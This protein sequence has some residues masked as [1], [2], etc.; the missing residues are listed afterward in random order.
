MREYRE[1]F[2]KFLVLSVLTFAAYLAGGWALWRF[3]DRGD[4]PPVAEGDRN[5]EGTFVRTQIG[6]E[7]I[8]AHSWSGWYESPVHGVSVE[9][10]PPQAE[11]IAKIEARWPN[12]AVQQIDGHFGKRDFAEDLV[13]ARIWNGASSR[14]LA[15]FFTWRPLEY[16]EGDVEKG[17]RLEKVTTLSLQPGEWSDWVVQPDGTDELVVQ[18][19][20]YAEAFVKCGL[21]LDDGTMQVV[22]AA[23]RWTGQKVHGVRLRND[24]ANPV[25]ATILAWRPIATSSAGNASQTSAPSQ[26]YRYDQPEQA[27]AR[28]PAPR[29]ARSESAATSQPTRR[30]I[31][32]GYI[33]KG[34]RLET[35][36]QLALSPGEWS[37]WIVRPT[38]SS[39]VIV[40]VDNENAW[41]C[42]LRFL[43]DTEEEFQVADRAAWRRA[44]KAVRVRND[45]RASAIATVFAWRRLGVNVHAT[46]LQGV[47]PPSGWDTTRISRVFVPPLGWTN[48][49]ER[50]EGGW[51]M[52]VG[53]SDTSLNQG[54]TA[55]VRLPDGTVQQINNTDWRKISR[56]VV[57]ARVHNPASDRSVVVMF[58]TWRNQ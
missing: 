17:E 19:D 37:D 48:W 54:F 31:G 47:D 21:R 57:A 51:G 39:S 1:G 30:K 33:D 52:A 34:E 58:Y 24:G 13:A 7:E 5:T 18:M 46:A 43:D 25:S 28:S 35:V 53:Y 41:R 26:P 3:I 23:E 44:A 9:M 38:D 14:V 36:A 27:P 16:H 10:I 45:G 8:P 50:P 22:P 11:K 20:S 40:E 2:P 29:E 56:E 49:V 6:E 55:E 42:R 4:T 12:G 15:R 32:E